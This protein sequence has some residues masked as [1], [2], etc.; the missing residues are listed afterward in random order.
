MTII[1]WVAAALGLINVVLV[2]RRSL[3]NSTLR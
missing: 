3:W 1:E 2:A